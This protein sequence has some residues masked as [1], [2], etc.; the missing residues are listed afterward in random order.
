VRKSLQNLKNNNENDRENQSTNT[1]Q[2]TIT[3]LR[4]TCLTIL[5][6]DMLSYMRESPG[7]QETLV[8]A[9][10]T[11]AENSTSVVSKTVWAVVMGSPATAIFGA[12]TSAV[13]EEPGISARS[14]ATFNL[15]GRRTSP[16][17]C[18]AS[19]SSTIRGSAVCSGTVPN[20]GLIERL[21][22]P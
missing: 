8:M 4:E 22:E 14:P 15:F 2:L 5:P 7:R 19:G 13:D 9:W 6:E 21:V 3:K 12:Q 18:S 1:Y 16:S 20:S 17:A 10:A 11:R